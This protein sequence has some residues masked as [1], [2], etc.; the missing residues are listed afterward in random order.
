VD[1]EAFISGCETELE[2]LIG[3][4]QAP[5]MKYS[6]SILL[7]YADAEDAVQMAFINTYQNRERIRNINNLSAY[8]YRVTYNA[9]VDIIRI[10]RFIVREPQLPNNSSS[11]ISEDMQ[12]ALGKLTA[13]DR[14]L[15]YGRAVDELS[16]SELSEIHGKSEQSLRKRYERAKKKLIGL[17]SSDKQKN[18]K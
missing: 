9:S 2:K 4:M 6:Y 18:H 13:L 3:E 1:V 5:L 8:L 12:K 10:N 15:I 7:N 11:Y 14:A 17:L 16:Y